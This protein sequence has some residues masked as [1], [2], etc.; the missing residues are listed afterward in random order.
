MVTL[1]VFGIKPV[2][3]MWIIVYVDWGVHDCLKFIQANTTTIS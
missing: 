2:N 1:P 3:F